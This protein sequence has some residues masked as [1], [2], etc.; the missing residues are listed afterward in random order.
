MNGWIRANAWQVVVSVIGVLLLA[1]QYQE[2]QAGLAERVERL[3]TSAR[4]ERNR[5]DSVYYLR[6]LGEAQQVELV[7]RLAAI[8]AKLDRLTERGDR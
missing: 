7:R 8:E 5:L 2:R 6:A 3:E 4:E 1:G